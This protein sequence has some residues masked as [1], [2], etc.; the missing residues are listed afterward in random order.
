MG[1]TAESERTED[2]KALAI[3]YADAATGAA[4]DRAFAERV[5][6]RFDPVELEGVR[7]IGR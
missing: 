1:E 2:T 4:V 7:S 3:E 6:T 5:R